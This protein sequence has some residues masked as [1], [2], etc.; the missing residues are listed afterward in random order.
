MGFGDI[1]GCAAVRVRGPLGYLYG[2]A[3]DKAWRR[4]G[5][6]HALTQGR[7]NFLRDAGSGTAYVF[8]MFWNIRFF[9]R[10]GFTLA[11]RKKIPELVNLHRDFAENWNSRS[12]LLQADCLTIRNYRPTLNS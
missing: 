5:I 3:V 4:R 11:D 1:V 2:L 10:H 12:A 7:L 8:A 9:K 6:G